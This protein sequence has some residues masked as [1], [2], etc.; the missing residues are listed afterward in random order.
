MCEH[1]DN[2]SVGAG[3]HANST[4]A[5][6]ES[7]KIESEGEKS[8]TAKSKTEG[9]DSGRMWARRV[10]SSANIESTMNENAGADSENKGADSEIT[11]ADS[12]IVD[13]VQRV[14][15]QA[16][17]RQR[18]RERGGT[19]RE[20]WTARMQVQLRESKIVCA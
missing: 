19:Q 9:T 11:D 17:C 13:E 8:Q 1:R 5:N 12:E 10:K 16:S 6:S 18:E 3:A 2:N 14:R 7:T 20:P 15:V 4:G